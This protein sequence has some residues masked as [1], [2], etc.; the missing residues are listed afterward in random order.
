MSFSHHPKNI[1]YGLKY[2]LQNLAQFQEHS[3]ISNYTLVLIRLDVSP[4]I[5]S[6]CF[7]ASWMESTTTSSAQEEQKKKRTVSSWDTQT[8]RLTSYCLLK[9]ITS[10]SSSFDFQEKRQSQQL[11]SSE[12]RHMKLFRLFVTR[13]SCENVKKIMNGN[14]Y[15][16][17][18]SIGGHI[19]K[20]ISCC[21]RNLV[22]SKSFLSP[23]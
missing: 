23:I 18:I 2:S 5:R 7:I 4:A 9:T 6:L 10:T 16:Y 8:T 3:C 11:K 13:K 15:P 17:S 20:F 19:V 14:L 1:K 22:F 12:S 21:A